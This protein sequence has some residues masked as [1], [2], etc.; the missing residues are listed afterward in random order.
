[1]WCCTLAKQ[2]LKAKSKTL[3]ISEFSY[4]RNIFRIITSSVAR[5]LQ[6]IGNSFQT[7]RKTMFYTPLW[8]SQSFLILKIPQKVTKWINALD[9]GI[10]LDTPQAILMCKFP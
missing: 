7:F 8:P 2:A 3:K 5:R 4:L 6:T 10:N 1:M 9:D